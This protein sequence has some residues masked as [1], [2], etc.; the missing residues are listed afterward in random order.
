MT[1][2]SPEDVP[3]TKRKIFLSYGRDEYSRDALRV[4]AGLEARGHEVWFDVE[5][6]REGRDWEAWI[7]QGLQQCDLLVLL[8]TPYSVRRRDRRDPRSQDGYC[9]NEIAAALL[10]NK[11]IIP[12]LL[13]SLEPDGP[14]LLSAVSS[15]W[16]C[17]TRSLPPNGSL[18]S[19]S[20]LIA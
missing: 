5:R 19:R 8:M 15:T 6:L 14:R 4:K 1:I 16:T 3:R 7:E 17:V 9:L 18:S 2:Q 10:R 12:V 11:L 13:V 20:A